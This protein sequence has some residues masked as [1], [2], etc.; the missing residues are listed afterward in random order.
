[1]LPKTIPL[2]QMQTTWA[3]QLDPVISNQL[4]NGLLLPNLMLKSG[5][6]VINHKLG[7]APQG[8]FLVDTTAACQLY[9]SAPYNNLTITLNASAPTTAALWVF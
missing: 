4:V 5:D 8:W 6:N 7:R 2:S 3:A 1:M 9:R